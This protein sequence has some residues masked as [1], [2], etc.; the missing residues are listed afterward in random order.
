SGAALDRWP[1]VREA[2]VRPS[3][4]SVGD[5]SDNALGEAFAATPEGEW[6]DRRAFRSRAEARTAVFGCIEGWYDPLRRHPP[7]ATRRPSS[8]TGAI[9]PPHDR[10]PG[11]VHR[12]GTTP[13]GRS[14]VAVGG[15]G[16]DTSTTLDSLM[17]FG[18]F[19]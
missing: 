17:S 8:S 18:Q 9:G 16:V 14:P 6:L 3:A 19:G 7:S 5:A 4:G 1:A 15:R 10:K 2:G 11:T 13:Q 12:S